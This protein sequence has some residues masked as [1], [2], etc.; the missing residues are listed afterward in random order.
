MSLSRYQPATKKRDAVAEFRAAISE[1]DGRGVAR[2]TMLLRLT[3]SDAS[4]LKRSRDVADEEISFD[5]GM[6]F[7][8]VKVETGVV[9]TSELV[10]A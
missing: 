7:L 6:T 1:A 4:A 8:G 3:H 9:T 5:G 2:D 10:A